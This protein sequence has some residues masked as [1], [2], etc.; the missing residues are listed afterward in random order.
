MRQNLFD[1]HVEGPKPFLQ[2]LAIGPR[3]EQAVDVIDPQ[4]LHVAA[5]DQFAHQPVRPLEHFRQLHPQ[6]GKLIDIEETPIVDL[7]GGDAPIGD[8]VCLG[9]EKAMQTWEALRLPLPAVDAGEGRGNGTGN[10]RITGAF[11]KG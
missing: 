4:P 11:G 7:L 2:P 3:I 10:R 9:L 6:A 8:A 1:Q 5:L